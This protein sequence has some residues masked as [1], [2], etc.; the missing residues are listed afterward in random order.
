[1]ILWKS[2][3]G[4]IPRLLLCAEKEVHGVN[5]R[6]TMYK[7]QTALC[8]KGKLVR[9][10]QKQH[11]NEHQQK[12]VTKYQVLFDGW[13]EPMFESYK[14]HEVVQYLA[15]LLTGGGRE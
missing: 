15:G 5:A 3:E 7:L 11:W 4:A 1:M 9:I 10:N 14:A 8:A 2:G 6:R 12:M 13:Y